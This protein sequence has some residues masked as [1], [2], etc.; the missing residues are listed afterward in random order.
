MLASIQSAT[1]TN[2]HVTPAI[3]ELEQAEKRVTS[4]MCET[5]E[6]VRSIYIIQM[7]DK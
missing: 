6:A 3:S 1:V 2:F 5:I 4:R 7:A